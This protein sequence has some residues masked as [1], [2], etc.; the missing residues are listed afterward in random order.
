MKKIIFICM[1]AT[2]LFA[3]KSASS[4]TASTEAPTLATKLDKSTQVALKGNWVLTNVSYPGSEYIKVNS[5]DLADSKCFIGSTWSFISNNNKG[6]M[7]LT[8]PSCTSFSS[9][10]VWSINSQGMFILKIL[11]AGVKAKK[12]RDGYLLK[13]AGVTDS[14]FQLIDNINV[15]GQVKDVTYQFQRAN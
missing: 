8:A 7:A 10:I 11:D 15:G 1:I 5:F 6:S 3:C 9:P 4:T 2:M 14:S 12:V 13:V